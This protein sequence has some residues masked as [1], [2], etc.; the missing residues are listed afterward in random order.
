MAISKL[1]L[2]AWGNGA[3]VRQ[4]DGGWTRTALCQDF[5]RDDARHLNWIGFRV[6]GC[7]SGKA[8]NQ[9]RTCPGDLWCEMRG[10]RG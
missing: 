2:G 7:V 8:S 10:G 1:G 3:R 6:L 9:Y 4:I 5:I